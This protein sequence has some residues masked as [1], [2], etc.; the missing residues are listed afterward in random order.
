MDQACSPSKSIDSVEITHPSLVCGITLKR[1]KLAFCVNNESESGSNSQAFTNS[2]HLL[3]V[4]FDGFAGRQSVASKTKDKTRVSSASGS[5]VVKHKS[6]MVPLI[7]TNKDLEGIQQ[8]MKHV[9]DTW[10][11]LLENDPWFEPDVQIV[12]FTPSPGNQS[13]PLKDGPT[14]VSSSVPILQN[15][16][17]ELMHNFTAGFGSEGSSPR[18]PN[19]MLQEGPDGELKKKGEDSGES[20]DSGAT[21][22]EAR[23]PGMV[24]QCLSLPSDFCD[25]SLHVQSIQPTVDR[26][27][28]I[29]VVAPTTQ[30]TSNANAESL[31]PLTLQ[32]GEE[33]MDV[34]SDKAN[35]NDN[36]QTT[37]GETRVDSEMQIQSEDTNKEVTAKPECMTNGHSTSR[38]ENGNVQSQSGHLGGL[39]VYKLKL[40]EGRT[41]LE[42][43]PCMVYRVSKEGES[44][45][46]ML[47]LPPEVA[48]QLDEEESLTNSCPLANPH[49]SNG[50]G[51]VGQ[52][53]LIL[54]NGCMVIL[55]LADTRVISSLLPEEGDGF[56]SAAYCTGKCFNQLTSQDNRICTEVF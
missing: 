18:S 22:I 38:V 27:Y 14:T 44:I 30:R 15:G 53:S 52:V 1:P 50:I 48:E 40:V 54:A 55:N 13:S 39:L 11:M 37:N 41:L 8:N 34:D 47:V 45:R 49:G 17:S 9:N 56:V 6:P 4:R 3:V 26:R 46:D 21:V 35:V 33:P 10:S 12:G 28:V 32:D 20:V 24:L 25:S 29:V 2:P 23:M 5:K 19:I 16:P 7:D 51:A 42:E 36:E 31:N 43:W